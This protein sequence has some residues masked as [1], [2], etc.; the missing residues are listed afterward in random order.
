VGGQWQP[1]LEVKKEIQVS[2]TLP[3]GEMNRLFRFL[4]PLILAAGTVAVGQE[5][6][7]ADVP[8]PAPKLPQRVR[9]SSGVA[10]GLSIKKSRVEPHYPEEAKGARIQGR[11]VLRAESSKDGIVQ[12]LQLVSGDPVLAQAAIEA[13]K[14]WRYKPYLLNGEPV[15][16][17]TQVVVDFQLR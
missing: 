8:K 16:M 6:N 11:V 13:V 5:S 4:V 1:L 15:A 9:V 12:D 2:A 17:E 10:V 3:R 7:N 14:Q